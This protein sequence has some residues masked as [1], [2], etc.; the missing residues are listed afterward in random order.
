M[1]FIDNIEAQEF[2]FLSNSKFQHSYPVI[3][4]KL[5]GDRFTYCIGI[6]FLTQ[7]Y[8]LQYLDDTKPITG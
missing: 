5:Q 4:H 8:I 7:S 1:L 3:I 2:I 6:T